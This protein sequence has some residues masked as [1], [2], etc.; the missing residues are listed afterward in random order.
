MKRALV[1]GASGF[2]GA[3]LVR[4]LLAE[5]AEV[6]LFTRP[7]SNLWRLEEIRAD[8]HLHN[9]DLQDE[10]AVQRAVAQ[11]RPEWIFHLAVFGAYSFQ[12]DS[13]RILQTNILGTANLVQACAKVDFE[14]FI[15]TGSSSE[16]GFKDHPTAEGD[17]PEPNSYYAV[18]KVSA[19]FYCS[20]VAR[21]LGRP[22]PTLRL[23]SVYGAYE[24][25]QRLMPTLI[26]KGLAG[27]LP[28]LVAPDTARDFVYVDDVCQAY[29]MAAQSRTL[30][31]GEVLNVGSGQQLTI[32]EVVEVARQVLHIKQTPQWGSMPGRIW[33]S[34]VWSADNRRIR[35]RLGWQPKLDFR[36]GFVKMV[37]WFREHRHFY[38]E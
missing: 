21:V 7:T 3:N 10:S 18:S 23:Y 13:T 2:V 35:E 14:A 29:L 28:P 9:V 36:A 16:Y 15:N 27:E 4:R 37:D 19:T 31:F 1:T 24:E 26:Q 11:I 33:D 38:A 17:L 30:E 34:S 32:R 8:L 5:G 25:P 20:Y 12:T 22:I 6:H